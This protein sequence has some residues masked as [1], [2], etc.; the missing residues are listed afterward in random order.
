[1]GRRRRTVELTLPPHLSSALGQITKQLDKTIGRDT[2]LMG[3]GTTLAAR[4]NHRRSTDLD[5]FFMDVSDRPLDQIYRTFLKDDRFIE[6][7]FFG[8]NGFEGVFD[9]VP[10]SFIRT[11]RYTDTRRSDHTING[12][13]TETTAEILSKKLRGRIISQSRFPIRD[14]YDLVVGLIHDPEH[15]TSAFEQIEAT[16]R[17]ILIRDSDDFII[18][19]SRKLISAKY[20]ELTSSVVLREIVQHMMRY[21]FEKAHTQIKRALGTNDDFSG[22]R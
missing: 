14:M 8:S 19:Q 6:G 1:M 13:S 10:F 17:R 4:W 12:I 7:M 11:L 15:T 16:P 18:D 9:G 21:D 2:Y 22:D 5:L 20:P 3:G